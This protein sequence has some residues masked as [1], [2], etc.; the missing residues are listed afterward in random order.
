MPAQALYLK[1]RPRTFTEV[2]GQEHIT[3]TLKNALALNRIAHAYLFTGPRG[4]GKTTSARLLAKAVNCLSDGDKPCNTCAICTAI[5]EDRMLDLIEIDAASNTSVE[6]IRDLRDK[7]DFRPGEAKY[8]FYIIDECFRYEDLITLADGTKL[9]IGKI[10]EDKLQAP[11]LSYN[12]Q[13]GRIESKPIVRH[14]RKTP[15]LPTVRITFDNNRALVCTINHKFYT[16]NGMVRAGELDAGQFVYAGYKRI[17][18]HQLE[19]I[20]GAAIGDGHLALTGSQMRARLSINQGVTQR[21]YLEYKRDLLGDTV[22][23]APKFQLSPRSFTKLGTVHLA[24]LS[25][26]QIAELRDELYDEQGRKRISRAYLDRLTPLGLALWY[27]DDGSLITHTHPHTRKDGSTTSYPNSRATLATYGFRLEEAQIIL[28]WFAERWNIEGGMSATAKGPVIWL[29]VEGTRRLHAIIA[30]YVPPSMEYKLLP[31]Y[32]GRFC[33]PTDDG[34]PSGLA[35]SAVKRIERVPAPDVVYNI[36]VADNHNYFARDI[37]VAN[38][39]ML[40]NSAFN[41]LLKTLEEPP[42]H[43]IFIL[44]TTDP[45]KI[46]ATVISRVQ[47]FDF[48]RLTLPEIIA[49]LTEIAQKENL[50]VEP[51]AIELIARQSTGAMRDAISLLDQLTAYGSDQITLAQVEGLLGAASQRIV[52]EIVAQLAEKNVAR[53]LALIASAVDAGADP[54][55]LSREIVEYIRGLLLIKMGGEAALT[56]TAE[57]LAEMTERAG[58]FAAEQILRAIRLFNQ[59]GFELR[60]S[61]HP[62][63]PLEI[64]FVE[65]TL[66]ERVAVA[67]ARAP[68]APARTT[69][70]APRPQ[71]RA[72]NPAPKIESAPAVAIAEGDALTIELL[73][74]HWNDLLAEIGKYNKITQA[75][76]RDAE[77]INIENDV[78]TLG[79][80]FHAERFEKQADNKTLVEKVFFKIFKRKLRVK[81]ILSP[82]KAK[83]K[84]VADDPLIRNAVS[85]WGAQIT[86]IHHS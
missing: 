51:A 31:A 6:N 16:P 46:P 70:P 22:A 73:Q 24:S 9:P 64:A 12:E 49:R 36:E 39:H 26:P 2:E 58:Q 38:C 84:A 55:K 43:V 33:P 13:T 29:T 4:T 72:E 80:Q 8:K 65:A 53:G 44:A 59:A 60:A 17:T 63:L 28:Q 37:L 85:Q 34:T 83:L 32:R 27:L 56:L 76:L 52:G 5:N 23:S 48:R 14:M 78:V 71:S 3:T 68:A 75:L 77:P 1:Y 41:A 11:V 21:A 86:D 30:P 50:R 20:A 15:Q 40:S 69:P 7:V 35:I 47:R 45:Q 81:S 67:P 66:E 62:T 18:Q 79:F 10:V 54:R 82:K 61:A 25:Y 42:P 19:V 74:A 57:S